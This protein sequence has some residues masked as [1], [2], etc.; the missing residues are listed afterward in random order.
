MD[1]CGVAAYP[2][3]TAMPRARRAPKTRPRPRRAYHHGDL[4][5][6][7]VDEAVRLTRAGSG[8]TLSI[9]DVARRIGVSHNA[10][11]AHFRNSEDLLAAVAARGLDQLAERLARVLHEPQWLKVNKL[12]A[13][14]IAYVHFAHEETGLFRAVFLSPLGN[15]LERPEI[16]AAS[17]RV[18]GV[19]TSAVEQAQREGVIVPDDAREIAL[20]TWTMIHGLAALVAEGRLGPLTREEIERHVK[21][22]TRRL[23]LGLAPPEIASARRELGSRLY[24]VRPELRGDATPPPDADR[25]RAGRGEPSGGTD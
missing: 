24:D 14:C 12:E 22:A 4:R 3:R 10:P 19:V 23:Y 5:N 1:P 8:E 6:A 21:N 7:L 15:P 11:Y 17:E 2:G 16:A 18:L 9:R 20:V 25:D 13:L